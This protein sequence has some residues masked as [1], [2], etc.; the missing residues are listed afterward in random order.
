MRGYSMGRKKIQWI[1]DCGTWECSECGLVWEF[2][3]DGPAEN[4]AYYCPRCGVKL[5]EESNGK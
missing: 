1:E 5:L 2:N 4:Q 3:C